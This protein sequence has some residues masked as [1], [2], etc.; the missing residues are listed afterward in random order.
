MIGNVRL[1]C[2]PKSGQFQ[3]NQ[4][5]ILLTPPSAFTTTMTL[6]FLANKHEIQLKERVN[7]LEIL[8]DLELGNTFD[9]V[10]SDGSSGV[11]AEESS[12]LAKYFLRAG[13]PFTQHVYMGNQ[14]VFD[15]KRTWKWIGSKMEIMAGGQCVAIIEWNWPKKFLLQ[16]EFKI[17]S[18][19]KSQHLL[20]IKGWEFSTWI[21][22]KK[23]WTYRVVDANSGNQVGHIKKKFSGIIQEL[24]TDADNFEVQ[25]DVNMPPNLKAAVLGLVFLLNCKYY[26]K[27]KSN[28]NNNRR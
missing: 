23:P 12:A 14:L 5:L 9:L 8:T 20:T 1:R 18:P 22:G 2:S 28:N 7:A 13:R 16:R 21:C 24:F 3:H 4:Q 19:D 26:T 15:A 17:Y 11:A 10:Y 27:P 25:F 6:N